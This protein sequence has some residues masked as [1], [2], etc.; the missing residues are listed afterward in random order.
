[1][2]EMRLSGSTSGVWKRGMMGIMRHRQTK[3]PGTDRPRLIHRVTP[4]LYTVTSEL[5]TTHQRIPDWSWCAI[6]RLAIHGHLSED[7]DERND[8]ENDS[9]SGSHDQSRFGRLAAEYHTADPYAT[10]ESGG[11]SEGG[12]NDGYEQRDYDFTCRRF[13]KQ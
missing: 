6:C 13:H 10:H 12:G 2:R 3:G 11:R 5:I 4:R 1:M 7:D 8:G 9:S